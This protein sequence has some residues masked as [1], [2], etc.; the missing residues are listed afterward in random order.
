MLKDFEVPEGGKPLLLE[1]DAPGLR[2]FSPKRQ[3]VVVPVVGDSEPVTFELRA[4]EPGRRRI[5]ISAW[6]DGS[7]LG[8]LII[9][10]AVRADARVRED[11]TARGDMRFGRI[12]GEVTL[13]VRRDEARRYRFEFR[14]V[15]NPAEVKGMLK[16]DP[17]SAVERLLARLDG[18]AR[19]GR[20]PTGLARDYLVNAG[21]ELWEELIP[22][23]LRRQFWERQGRIQHLTI[24]SEADTVPW[25]LLYPQDIGHEAGFLVEQFPVT[26][27]VFDRLP[28]RSLRLR[29]AC[30]VLPHGSP[31]EADI[32]VAALH[33]LLDPDR[34]HADTV[35]T[36]PPLL[37]LIHKG[38]FGVLH[39]AC[40]SRFDPEDGSTIHLDC[41]FL[42]MQL[43]KAGSDRTLAAHTPLIFINACRSALGVASYNRLDSWA[44][45]FLR[46]GAGAFIGSLWAVSDG[47]ARE[48]AMELYRRLQSGQA[49][50]AAVMSARTAAASLPGDPTWLAYAAYGNSLAKVDTLP[51]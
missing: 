14:D 48:F 24:L 26:R 31:P 8:Q 47:A 34:P 19:G 27:A 10:V 28:P 38:D 32:E 49:L 23:G 13:V 41:P 37:E 17:G 18:L 15:D 33:M 35:A 44:E 3:V 40:H 42:P 30:F 45:K 50:G 20:Y 2:I 4:N 29:P 36:L 22:E 21:L 25:E 39:F 9:E 6:D 5:S 11:Q 16:Y 1:A 7:C 51:G 12:D 46:A 43:T